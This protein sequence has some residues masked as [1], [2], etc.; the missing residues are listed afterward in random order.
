M[1]NVPNTLSIDREFAKLNRLRFL[2]EIEA[3]F[4][5][6]GVDHRKRVGRISLMAGIFIFNMFPFADLQIM[7]DIF[8]PLALLRLG[9]FTP[10]CLAILWLLPR[11]STTQQIDTCAVGGTVLGVAI[12]VVASLYSQS[13]YV[14]IYQFGTMITMTYFTLVQRVRF[15]MAVAGLAIILFI[16]LYC[17]ALRTD[18][19]APS[20]DFVVNF[21]VG[22]TTLLLLGSFLQERAERKGFLERLRSDL[23][24]EHIEWAARTD[25]L[26][27]MSNRHHLAQI[28]PTFMEVAARQPVAALMIDIDHFKL[29]N[30][31]QGHLAGDHCIRTVARIIL[32]ALEASGQGGERANHAFR[33]GGEEFLLL[34]TGRDE[35]QATALGEAIRLRLEAA[36]IA[37]PGM[38][39]G[40]L[41]TASIGI[42]VRRWTDVDLEA[43][44]GAADTALYQAKAGGRNRLALAA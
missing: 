38:G 6:E 20:F 36:R 39:T 5:A 26:T 29:F 16:Q 35:A 33:F 42:A 21:F 15:R 11:T 17:V 30:D 14:L 9:L 31:T 13:P 1:S 4:D 2:P 23:L 24:V 41:L 40:A 7:P 32:D 19:D 43:L 8:L 44:I 34:L 12:P 22:G 25:M 27:G 10:A 37:H 18:I 28:S 3:R